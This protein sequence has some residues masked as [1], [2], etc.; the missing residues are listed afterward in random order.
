MVRHIVLKEIVL[1]LRVKN[2][3]ELIRNG[4]GELIVR[5]EHFTYP[6]SVRQNFVDFRGGG[7]VLAR[8]YFKVRFPNAICEIF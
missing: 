8:D 7:V 4:E 5:T 1:L 6:F 3:E 2:S